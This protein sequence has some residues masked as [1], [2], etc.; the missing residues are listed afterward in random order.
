MAN[1]GQQKRIADKLKRNLE[2][3]LKASEGLSVL[4]TV[5]A[6]GDHLL[7]ITD[8]AWAT[9]D[10]N[11]ALIKIQEMPLGDF[12][13][14]GY[15]VHK[16]MICLENAAAGTGVYLDAGLFGEYLARINDMGCAIEVYASANTDQP[17]DQA[18]AGG[19]F[20]AG[21]ATLR[22][23]IRASVDTLGLGQ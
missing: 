19:T 9:S 15:P 14:N 12:P 10:S 20:N 1:Y 7:T 4:H 23:H 8:G 16:V 6:V 22:R 2:Q 3:I 18:T 21:A 13:V 17:A 5:N 11:F